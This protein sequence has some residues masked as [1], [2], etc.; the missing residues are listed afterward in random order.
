MQHNYFTCSTSNHHSAR[1][2]HNHCS[3]GLTTTIESSLTTPV[4]NEFLLV[5]KKC[6]TCISQFVCAFV[7]E[8]DDVK[9]PL[10]YLC[11][12]TIEIHQDDIKPEAAS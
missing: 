6:S 9:N 10:R 3:R 2:Y 4:L 7:Q 5:T 1:F 11:Q 12:A 8:E